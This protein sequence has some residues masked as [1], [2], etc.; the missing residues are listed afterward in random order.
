MDTSVVTA[1]R[2][3][4]LVRKTF[5][6]EAAHVLPHHDGKC[7]R[8]HGHSW[9]LQVE[10]Q[11]KGLH[12]TG[13]KQGMLLD[14]GDISAVVKPLLEDRLDHYYLN[15][16]TGLESPTSERL[17]AWIYHTLLA[18]LPGLVAVTVEETCTSAATYRCE[19]V[20]ELR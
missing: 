6:F 19:A 15:E 5:R 1:Y 7:A 13:P 12:T 11:G 17:A 20:E 8:L 4:Y 16:S 3:R 2:T 14:F 10:I 18:D 9:V